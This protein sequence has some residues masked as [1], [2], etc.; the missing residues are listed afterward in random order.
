MASLL[1]SRKFWLAVL[2]LVQTVLFQYV[3]G[4]PKEVWLAIDAFLIVLIGSIAYEDGQEKS[5]AIVTYDEEY[6]NIEKHLLS[7]GPRRKSG[8]LLWWYNSHGVTGFCPVPL[9]NSDRFSRTARY[10]RVCE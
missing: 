8:A 1:K 4:F 9:R 6:G 10:K 5:T 3:P 7:A 2:A